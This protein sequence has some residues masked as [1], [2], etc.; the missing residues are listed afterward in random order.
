MKK[1]IY[2]LPLLTVCVLSQ[3]AQEQRVSV[4]TPEGIKVEAVWVPGADSLRLVETALDTGSRFQMIDRPVIGD[5]DTFQG[6]KTCALSSDGQIL[7]IAEDKGL[8]YVHAIATS[9]WNRPIVAVQKGSMVHIP[10]SYSSETMLLGGLAVLSRDEAARMPHLSNLISSDDA[11]HLL[12]GISEDG[13][14]HVAF[15]L[16]FDRMLGSSAMQMMRICSGESSKPGFCVSGSGDIVDKQSSFTQNSAHDSCCAYEACSAIG[17][18]SD[19]DKK[20]WRQG[21]NV[22]CAREI[23]GKACG[24]EE[25]RRVLT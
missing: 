8:R 1:S 14:Q 7:A 16:F 25:G 6:V 18:W 22:M 23:F 2:I 4:Q 17:Q 13:K 5:N 3:A 12:V 15:E 21:A 19:D 24:P 10:M 20:L 9:G 11:T